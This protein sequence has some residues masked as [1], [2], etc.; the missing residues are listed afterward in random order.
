LAQVPFYQEEEFKE[1]KGT[2]RRKEVQRQKKRHLRH[3]LAASTREVLSSAQK[4]ISQLPWLS[5][6]MSAI[7]FLTFQ[8]DPAWGRLQRQPV[9]LATSLQ[10]PWCGLL[11][12]QLSKCPGELCF[13]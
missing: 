11:S 1:E 10:Y 13:N 8:S 3:A 2:T 7:Y 4:A 12:G 9:L 5:V 6:Q